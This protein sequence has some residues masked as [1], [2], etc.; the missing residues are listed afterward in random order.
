ARARVSEAILAASACRTSITEAS[1]T[2]L[3]TVA[4]NGFGCGE[5]PTAPT[6]GISQYVKSLTTDANG[7]ITV[8]AQKI[9]QLGSNVNLDLIPYTDA[10]ANTAAVTANFQKGTEKA[11]IAW[12]CKPNGTNGIEAKYLPASCRG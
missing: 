5:T 12:V 7:V 4:A 11:V 10:T 8:Q 2:G 9:S 3:D 1:Q 6:D